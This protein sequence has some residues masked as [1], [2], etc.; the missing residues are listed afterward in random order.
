MN[1]SKNQ[2]HYRITLAEALANYKEGLITANGLLYFYLK[3]RLAP[4]WKCTLNQREISS[5]LGI[6]RAAFYKAIAKLSEKGLIQF[7]TP[8]GVTVTL[9]ANR[10]STPQIETQST[11]EDSIPRS[12]TLSTNA[13]SQSSIVDSTP[14]IE[15]SSLRS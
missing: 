9:S 6:S 5:R 14:Q 13:D 15:T 12:D 11:F 10:D 1:T 3:I 4:G 7:E 2:Q 8:N